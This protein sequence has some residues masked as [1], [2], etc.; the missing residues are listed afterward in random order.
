MSAKHKGHSA[1]K[2]KSETPNKG[3]AGALR[4]ACSQDLLAESQALGNREMQRQLQASQQN[5][6]A[7]LE[8]II[9][10]LSTMRQ[11]QLKENDLLKSRD[12]WFIPVHRGAEKLPNPGRWK[13][14]ATE[15]KAAAVALCRGDIP[16]GVRLL[17]RAQEAESDAHQ[18]LPD[19]MG[20]VKR[21]PA[22]SAG[23]G[24]A[25]TQTAPCAPPQSLVIADRIVN[26]NPH[27]SDASTRKKS[28]HDW[29][30]PEEEENEEDDAD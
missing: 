28:L 5:R 15:Y 12:E 24:D 2:S 18:G 26:L 27:V 4:D 6:E 8:F 7:L 11:L 30:G 23:T 19:R 22:I 17:K 25:P 1:A 3:D 14:A 20:T 21:P 29:F 16:R 13:M 10:R 9:G